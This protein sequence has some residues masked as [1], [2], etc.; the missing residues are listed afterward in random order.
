MTSIDAEL[1]HIHVY[2]PAEARLWVCNFFAVL[3]NQMYLRNKHH[4]TRAPY[5]DSVHKIQ[6]NYTFIIGSKK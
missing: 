3:K 1:V 6:L 5:N 4:T 2:G